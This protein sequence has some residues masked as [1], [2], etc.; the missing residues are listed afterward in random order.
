MT[1]GHDP[2][3]AATARA[4]SGECALPE[5]AMSSPSSAIASLKRFRSSARAIAPASAPIIS[6]PHSSSTPE[7]ASSVATLSAVCPPSVGRIASGR[8]RRTTAATL[9]AVSGST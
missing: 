6:T 2:I 5:R 7:R 3:R 1:S 9:F 8:S 4:S